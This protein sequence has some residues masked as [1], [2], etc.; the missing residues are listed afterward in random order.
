LPQE[1]WGILGID[2]LRHP[3]PFCTLIFTRRRFV[4][5]G[6]LGRPSD[7]PT[8]KKRNVAEQPG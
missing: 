6:Y 4:S 3:F 2:M 8:L 1:L 5:I 7:T